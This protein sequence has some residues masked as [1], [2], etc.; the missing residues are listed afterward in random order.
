ILTQ[1]PPWYHPWKR[2]RTKTAFNP[3]IFRTDL[4]RVRTALR[5][6]G[7]YE[8]SVT[9]DLEPDGE[10]ITIV[11]HVDEGPAARVA[12]V[13]LV[14]SDFTSSAD[15]ETALRRELTLRPN[16]P[17]TQAQYDES[18]TRLEA[19]YQQRSYAYAHVDK[20]AVVDT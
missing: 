12:S 9:H 10:A 15:E 7:H 1:R 6:S 4:E 19:Y 16:A 8:S 20:T 2:W 5:E 14:T 3:Q 18:R 11:L 17:F 13:N